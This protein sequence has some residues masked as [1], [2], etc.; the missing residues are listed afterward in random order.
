MK[1]FWKSN[2]GIFF[3]IFGMAF[4][5]FGFPVFSTFYNDRV[6]PRHLPAS[7]IVQRFL[8]DCKETI[9]AKRDKFNQL[10]A[11]VQCGNDVYIWKNI[12]KFRIILSFDKTQYV[13][14]V[15]YLDSFNEID[16]VDDFRNGIEYCELEVTN[17]NIEFKERISCRPWSKI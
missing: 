14:Q 8:N 3:F 7:L 16:L 12:L 6:R 15:I 2:R 11:K 1:E 17:K 4:C 5:Y 10:P 9:E 13:I